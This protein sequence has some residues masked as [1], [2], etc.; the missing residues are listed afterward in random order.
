MKNRDSLQKTRHSHI[1]IH[2][3]NGFPVFRESWRRRAN[4]THRHNTHTTHNRPVG[5]RPPD[6]KQR[7]TQKKIDQS[8]T[9]SARTLVWLASVWVWVWVWVGGGVR[10]VRSNR[11]RALAKEKLGRH[12][13]SHKTLDSDPNQPTNLTPTQKD[14][15]RACRRNHS[16]RRSRRAMS[17]YSTCCRT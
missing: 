13:H 6:P 11:T 7:P 5:Y 12:T 14:R 8:N 4:D 1:H 9:R 16:K 2:T 10:T 3:H 15:D 17:S